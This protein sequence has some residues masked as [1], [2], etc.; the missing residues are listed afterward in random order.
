MIHLGCM[1]LDVLWNFRCD[2][3]GCHWS[4]LWGTDQA[5]QILPNYVFVCGWLHY[6]PEE[7]ML[8]SS[9]SWLYG[10]HVCLHIAMDLADDFVFDYPLTFF[11]FLEGDLLWIPLGLEGIFCYFC[12]TKFGVLELSRVNFTKFSVLECFWNLQNPLFL[13]IGLDQICRACAC[14]CFYF[15]F[16]LISCVFF[17]CG[18]RAVSFLVLFG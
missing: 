8:S 11:I 17:S 2:H 5:L 9:K 7:T 3:I 18:P 10:W 4:Y 14:F 13:L 16:L 1:M 12:F 15:I 6:Q